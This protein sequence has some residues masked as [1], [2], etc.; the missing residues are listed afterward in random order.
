MDNCH[1]NIK[2]PNKLKGEVESINLILV[3][4]ESEEEVTSVK[5][6]KMCEALRLKVDNDVKDSYRLGIFQLLSVT[7]GLYLIR[8]M[9]ENKNYVLKR[10]QR[11]KKSRCFLQFI[12]F[13][14]ADE[15]LCEHDGGITKVNFFSHRHHYFRGDFVNV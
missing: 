14:F 13:A 7:T 6:L 1:R 4:F 12:L 10:S 9:S 8:F 5:N 11:K 2:S 15:K 3:T